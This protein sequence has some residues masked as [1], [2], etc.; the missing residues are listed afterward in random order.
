MQ[1]FKVGDVVR[2]V[3]GNSFS[4]GEFEVTV[5]TV[6]PNQIWIKETGTWT[7]PECLVLAIAR[8]AKSTN[9]F[10]KTVTETKLVSGSHIFR[11]S[12]ADVQIE[13]GKNDVLIVTNS[14]YNK[15]DLAE[16]ARILNEISEAM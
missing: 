10:L 15:S 4:N 13:V 1:I 7:A 12:G 14:F 5:D 11:S 9:P 3:S 6:N 2:N 16:L 8:T